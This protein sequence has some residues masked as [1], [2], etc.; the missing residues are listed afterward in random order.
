MNNDNDFVSIGEAA[1][2]IGV[3]VPTLR[4]WEKLGKFVS[5][6]RTFGNH[7]RYKRID[8]LS[9]FNK[10]KKIHVA[11]ARV[12]SHDQKEDLERQK[13]FLQQHLEKKVLKIMN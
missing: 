10:E 8:V 3:S 1:I 13:T 5:N 12:S 2:L 4:R 11:Y 9:L 7:R 6:F